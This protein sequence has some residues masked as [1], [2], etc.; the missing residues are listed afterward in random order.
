MRGRKKTFFWLTHSKLLDFSWV[1]QRGRV[2]DSKVSFVFRDHLDNQSTA[3]KFLLNIW[4]VHGQSAKCWMPWCPRDQH[5]SKCTHLI[6]YIWS[7]LK[8]PKVIG[9]LKIIQNET[10]IWPPI[11]KF[12]QKKKLSFS[13]LHPMCPERKICFPSAQPLKLILT[14][15]S[16]STGD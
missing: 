11:F 5:L 4:V 16:V 6:L 13:F 9:K 3:K 10:E 15:R 8:G 14:L 2:H 12:M 1:G 7:T